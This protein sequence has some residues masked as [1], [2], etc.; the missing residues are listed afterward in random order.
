M[1]GTHLMVRGL[2]LSHVDFISKGSGK[3]FV[4]VSTCT[5]VSVCDFP[6]GSKDPRLLHSLSLHTSVSTL[7]GSS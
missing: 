3:W 5:R 7:L 1:G 4:C 2:G 6:L